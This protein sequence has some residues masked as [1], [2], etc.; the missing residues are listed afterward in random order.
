VN[1]TGALLPQGL[2]PVRSAVF[3]RIGQLRAG[4]ERQTLHVLTHYVTTSARAAVHAAG[5]GIVDREGLMTPAGPEK[6]ALIGGLRVLGAHANV[7]SQ[8]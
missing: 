3:S 4:G 7:S 1:A 5:R 6:A 8:S 2:R